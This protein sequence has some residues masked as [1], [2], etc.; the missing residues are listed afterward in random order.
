MSKI[1]KDLMYLKSHEWVK[2]EGDTAIIG[3]TDFAQDTLGSIV[4][5]EVNSVGDKVKQNKEFGTIES[6]KAASDLLTPLSGTIIEVNEEIVDKP[7]LINKDPYGCWLIKIKLADK[8]E[9]NNL[10]DASMY[11][12]ECH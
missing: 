8:D 9:I 1:L 4:Y 6:V 2:V 5:L 7:E 3:I 10:L 11:D 12:L